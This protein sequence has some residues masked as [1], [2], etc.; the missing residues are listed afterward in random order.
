MVMMLIERT[1]FDLKCDPC[2]EYVDSAT[3]SSTDS[4]PYYSFE[5]DIFL[6]CVNDMNII[7]GY[8]L[9]VDSAVSLLN[10]I[11]NNYITPASG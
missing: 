8:P 11:L 9:F 2:H 6:S 5:S 7:L 10:G 1:L 3:T 4:L